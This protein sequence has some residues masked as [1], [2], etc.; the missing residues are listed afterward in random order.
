MV[1]DKACIKQLQN[2]I[3]LNQLY[4]RAV[5]LI[6]RHP[7]QYLM[8]LMSIIL[9]AVLSFFKNTE[10]IIDII[11]EGKQYTE[12]ANFSFIGQDYYKTLNIDLVD[13]LISQ[14]AGFVGQENKVYFKIGGISLANDSHGDASLANFDKD[15]KLVGIINNNEIV[16]NNLSDYFKLKNDK[17]VNLDLVRKK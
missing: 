2:T 17:E 8:L 12:S 9:K 3:I 4:M 5:T 6:L 13:L 16:I 11:S 15:Y 1:I 10:I 14:Y 7:L